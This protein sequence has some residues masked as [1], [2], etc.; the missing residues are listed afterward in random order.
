[1]Q[2]AYILIEILILH[3]QQIILKLL[4]QSMK[5][6]HVETTQRYLNQRTLCLLPKKQ[7]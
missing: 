2:I 5:I 7:L 4:I 1:M 6:L 3:L